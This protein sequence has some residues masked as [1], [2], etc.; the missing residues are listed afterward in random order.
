MVIYYINAILLIFIVVLII[1]LIYQRH[2]YLEESLIDTN[3][4]LEMSK[5]CSLYLQKLNRQAEIINNYENE[6][7]EKNNGFKVIGD[8]IKKEPIYEGKKAIIGDYLACSSDNTKNVLKSLGFTVDVVP[9]SKELIETIKYGEHYDIIFSNNIYRDGTGPECLQELKKIK[10]FSTPV[11][12]H[13]ITKDARKQFV[14]G[15][16]FDEYIEKPITQEN[17]KP[18]LKK[19]LT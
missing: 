11:V 14:E 13:T 3:K 7:Y 2:K 18:I 5:K 12:I 6:E 9:S 8:T 17:I 16:G 1:L 15:I 10:G 4:L 19:L